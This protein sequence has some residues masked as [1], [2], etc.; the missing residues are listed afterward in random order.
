MQQLISFVIPVYN[1]LP[2]ELEECI[3]SIQQI[4]S[5]YE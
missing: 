4:T 5:L 2:F 1:N 3:K